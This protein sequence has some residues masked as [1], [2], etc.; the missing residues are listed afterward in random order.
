MGV[1]RRAK[2]VCTLGPAT[3]SPE[4]IRGLVEAGMDVAR[5][6]FSHGSHAE[7]ERVYRLVR[8]AA[9]EAGRP[10]A[11]LADLQG[12]KVRLGRFAH[13]PHEWR[14]G[15]TV[16]ITSEDILG[17]RD[18]VSCSYKKLPQEVKIGDRLLIDDGKVT[19]EVTSVSGNDIHCLVI[20]GGMVSDNK[21]VSLPNV[22][23]SVPA[24]S[25][26]DAADL[27]FARGLGG[28]LLRAFTRGHQARPRGDGRSGDSPPGARETGEAGGGRAP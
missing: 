18:R 3:S 19:I 27:R 15:D 13:G 16:I 1:T 20:E 14:T 10:L 9:R 12:P 21:G 28:A 5:L 8:E 4:R 7:H 25:E 2:I 26:K 22:A 11:I 17:T 23:V 6:N 24:L